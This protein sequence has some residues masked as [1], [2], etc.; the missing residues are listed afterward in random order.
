VSAD[1][2][3]DLTVVQLARQVA[4]DKR[5]AAAVLYV[6]SR[7]GSATA[8]EA[9]RQALERISARKPLV[10][11]M[12][13]AAASGGYWVSTPGRWIVA[14]PGTLTGSIGV[15]TGKIVTGDL[16]S[17]LLFNRETITFGEHVTLEQ[18]DKPFTDEERKIVQGDIDRIYG[19]FLE[20]V[21]TSRKM[22]RDELDPIAAGRVWTGRQALER[23]LVDEMGGVDAAVRKAR[24]LAGLRENAPAREVWAPRR[25]IP[26]RTFA[27]AAGYVSYL[28]D[29][30]GMLNRAPALAVMG[31][32]PDEPA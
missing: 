6:N 25:M 22:S 11:A 28:L 16:W 3:G 15:L 19:A 8:S 23:K 7:G 24:S 9:M 26:P 10:V 13:P 12:G 18:T 1:R 29:G 31:Y 32:L 14:R 27:G 2:S 5:A 21:G 4:A 20:L 17:K 30:I